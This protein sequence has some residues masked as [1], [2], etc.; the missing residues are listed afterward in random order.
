[1]ADADDTS[2]EPLIE[3]LRSLGEGPMWS[4]LLHGFWLPFRAIKF[5]YDRRTLWPLMIIPALINIGMFG[6]ILYL[7]WTNIGMIIELIWLEPVVDAWYDWLLKIAWYGLVGLVAVLS[8]GAAYAFVLLASGIVASPFNDRLSERVETIMLDRDEPPVRDDS[9]L[10]GIVRTIAS[11][12]FIFGSY[13]VVM[14]PILLL[15]FVP[16][17]GQIAATVLGAG[18]NALFLTVEFTDAPLDRR[19]RGL[20]QKFELIEGNRDIA[21]GFGLGCSILFWFPLFNLLIL[22]YAVVGGTALGI[23]MHDWDRRS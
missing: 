20:R 23:A 14:I 3:P 10:W 6:G 5:L 21:I 19:G 8:V 2:A 7:L 22:P 1:M 12:I 15:Y 9:M 17:I 11:S 13:C 4:R 18:V 16:P